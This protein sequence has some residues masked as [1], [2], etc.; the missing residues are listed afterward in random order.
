MQQIWYLKVDNNHSSETQWVQTGEQSESFNTKMPGEPGGHFSPSPWYLHLHPPVELGSVRITCR[1]NDREVGTTW[2]QWAERNK[3]TSVVLTVPHSFRE[4]MST[5]YTSSV[6]PIM[7]EYSAPWRPVIQQESS[8]CAAAVRQTESAELYKH[9]DRQT[10]VGADKQSR[11]RLARGKQNNYLIS[12]PGPAR[13]W[14]QNNFV[15]RVS[16]DFSLWVRVSQLLIISTPIFRNVFNSRRWFLKDKILS[17]YWRDTDEDQW[18]FKINVGQNGCCHHQVEVPAT[19][20]RSGEGEP[21][22]VQGEPSGGML[23][24]GRP[25]WR[26]S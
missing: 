26:G 24:A 9:Q 20:S 25:L 7:L 12:C 4:R 13:I 6:R 1:F 10:S 23:P 17:R 21:E 15:E 8:S 5:L 11:T 18:Y 22:D 19:P 14:F 3:K 2:R 16:S